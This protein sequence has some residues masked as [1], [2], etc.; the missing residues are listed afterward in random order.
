[1]IPRAKKVA[2]YIRNTFNSPKGKLDELISD[3]LMALM[4]PP[5]GDIERVELAEQLESGVREAL[6]QHI[7]NCKQQGIATDIEFGICSTIIINKHYAISEARD[8]FLKWLTEISPYKFEALCKKILEIEGCKNVQVTPPSA[9]GG[10]DFYGIKEVAIYNEYEPTIFNKID[11]LVIGQAKKYTIPIGIEEV[12]HF[13]GSI[14][15]LKLSKIRN[16]PGFL[17]C[18]LDDLSYKPHSPILLLFITS[19][20]ASPNVKAAAQWSGIRLITGKELI[21]ILYRNKMGFRI[22]ESGIKFDP[23]DFSAL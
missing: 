20:D 16:A 22:Y 11:V 2:D 14:E 10:I 13:I 3:A 6:S 7:E 23:V 15:L 4:D 21:D 17:P 8:D 1:M 18:I 5:P 9:D 19:G 12:R